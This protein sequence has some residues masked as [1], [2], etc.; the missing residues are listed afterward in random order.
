MM[1]E[2]TGLIIPE[3]FRTG[4]I[5]AEDNVA[6]FA[7]QGAFY[8][9]KRKQLIIRDNIT[10]GIAV[11]MNRSNGI[12]IVIATNRNKVATF[13]AEVFRHFSKRHHK[14]AGP[15]FEDGKWIHGSGADF[16]LNQEFCRLDGGGL[17]IWLV[18]FFSSSIWSKNL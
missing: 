13:C 6:E 12:L 11:H 18:H 1:G 7:G 16:V 10:D 3:I 14:N 4:T 15:V 8:D 9:M 17:I 2:T 5:V